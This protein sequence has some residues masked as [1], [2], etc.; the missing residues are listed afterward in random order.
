MTKNPSLTPAAFQMEKN[1]SVCLVYDVKSTGKKTATRKDLQGTICKHE[2]SARHADSSSYR[3]SIKIC[4]DGDSW[5]NI[6]HP[7]SALLGYERTFFDVLQE[8]YANTDMAWPGDTFQ[9]IRMEKDYRGPIRSATFNFFILSAG[10]NDVL[11]GGAL[12]NLLKWRNEGKGSSDPRNYI[13]GQILKLQLATL[14]AGYV[15][16]AA[17]VKAKSSGRTR[18][19]VH[20]YDY[21]VP[22]KDGVWL[23]RPFQD[24]GYDL[25]ADKTLIAEILKYLVDQFYGMLESVA[26][27]R[28]N[29]TVVDLRN[30]VRGRWD[31]ELHPKEPAS[32]DIAALF[33]E[34]IEPGLIA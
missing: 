29:V 3:S 25:Q 7:F 30:A 6:L 24:K 4:G 17:D 8:R 31:D 11:G 2:R 15:E 20:G 33:R 23:G 28:R 1:P 34:I 14:R 21:A 10:G 32:R 27:Q 19:L 9:Q 18:M 12:V 22:R 26:R 13:Y 16:I 5:I